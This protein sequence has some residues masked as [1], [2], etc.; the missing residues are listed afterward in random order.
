[1]RQLIPELTSLSRAIA[2]AKETVALR[3]EILT[4]ANGQHN[5]AADRIWPIPMSI[6]LFVRNSF[7]SR[8]LE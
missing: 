5:K 1:M 2:N 3:R 7:V 8:M 6:G 4:D